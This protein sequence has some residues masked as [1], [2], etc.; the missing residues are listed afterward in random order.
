M[1][2]EDADDLLETGSKSA[3]RMSI[4]QVYCFAN[5]VMDRLLD[6][7]LS[8]VSFMYTLY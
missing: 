6:Q 2:V 1:D 7:R 4:K 3:V 8:F 5:F